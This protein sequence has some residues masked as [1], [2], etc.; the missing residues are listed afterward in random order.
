MTILRLPWSRMY[1][2]AET[3]VS[4]VTNIMARNRW[5]LIKKHLHFNDNLMIL[6]QDPA[7]PNRL[8]KSSQL[9]TIYLLPKFQSILRQQVLC[10]DEQMIPFKGHSALKQYIP[11]NHTNEDTKYACYVIQLEW[12]TI[13]KFM[14]TGCWFFEF[15]SICKHHFSTC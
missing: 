5:K 3:R 2:A 12:F 13:L 1:W 4:N 7:N 14:I 15:G 10:C 11:K 6:E 8:L 9:L